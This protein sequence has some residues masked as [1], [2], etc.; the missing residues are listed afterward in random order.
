MNKKTWINILAIGLTLFVAAI[1]PSAFAAPWIQTGPNYGDGLELMLRETRQVNISI[2]NWTYGEDP[3]NPVVSIK[4]ITLLKLEQLEK[5][6]T[7]QI[8]DLEENK[9]HSIEQEGEEYLANLKGTIQALLNVKDAINYHEKTLAKA[10]VLIEHA[11]P[12]EAESKIRDADIAK[13]MMDTEESEPEERETD[14]DRVE[15]YISYIKDI[16]PSKFNNQQIKEMIETDVI[17]EKDIMY[18]KP[19]EPGKYIIIA[20]VFNSNIL[21]Q[22]EQNLQEGDMRINRAADDVAGLATSGRVTGTNYFEIYNVSNI[23]GALQEESKQQV[24]SGQIPPTGDYSKPLLLIIL[25]SLAAI[26]I[27]AICLYRNK[28]KKSM[29]NH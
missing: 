5:E 12:Q 18:E 4:D 22:T 23:D 1:G 3:K 29:Q 15:I 19:S 16:F 25:L 24:E 28:K 11:P 21:Q 9:Q 17:P 10:I 8:K 2:G 7:E 14:E 13:D 20:T 27:I 6:K 26:G